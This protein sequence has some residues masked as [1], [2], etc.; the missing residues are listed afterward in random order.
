MTA[1]YY[2]GSD[3]YKRLY[4]EPNPAFIYLKTLRNTFVQRRI[5]PRVFPSNQ[6]SDDVDIL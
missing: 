4:H 5:I 2:V 3:N 6:L 1:K